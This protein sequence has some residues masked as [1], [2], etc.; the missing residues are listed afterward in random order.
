[1]V[2]LFFFFNFC[3]SIVY[4]QCCVWW[5]RFSRSVVSDPLQPLCPRDSPGKST[6]AGCRFR[7][8]RIF[9][10][11]RSNLGLLHWHAGSL[12]TELR[13]KPKVVFNFCCIA[14]WL[15]YTYVYIHI[16]ILH[17]LFHSDLSQD[18][19]Y[20]SL[21]CAVGLCCLFICPWWSSG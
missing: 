11:Q 20:I 9:L 4:L 12:P 10:T 13:G 6:G 16:Y 5:W 18:I 2:C 3:W 21:H 1:M 17:I 8:Q 19:G 14:K 7:L 15:S